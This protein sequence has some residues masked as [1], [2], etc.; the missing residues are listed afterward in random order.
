MEFA[1]LA[2]EEIADGSIDRKERDLLMLDLPNVWN[3]NHANNMEVEMET[4][5]EMFMLS[6]GEHT[7]E[8]VDEITV[9]RFYALLAYIKE[10]NKPKKR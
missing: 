5:F 6:V 9:F 4:E 1:K 8:R 2:G 7:N 10:K 3:V